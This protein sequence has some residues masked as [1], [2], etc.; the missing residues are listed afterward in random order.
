[1]SD[2][3][4]SVEAASDA[5][6][7]LL[8]IT[9]TPERGD[10]LERLVAAGL[11]T[12]G[13]DLPERHVPRD[14]RPVE[15]TDRVTAAFA[16]R[17][18]PRQS[19]AVLSGGR[20]LGM[21]VQDCLI[22]TEAQPAYH[23]LPSFSTHFPYHIV[24]LLGFPANEAHT[25]NVTLQVFSAGTVRITG[26]GSPAAVVVGQSSIRLTVPVEVRTT[27]GGFASVMVQRVGQT[28]FDWFG[29]DVF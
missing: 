17:V 10:V 9:T 6:T 12:A 16:G 25:V 23:R 29:A 26:T 28:G 5:R 13:R 14:V 3:R 18:D 24:Y 4:S 20:V 11:V 22:S 1:M 19:R 15:E 27:A 21:Y 7:T 2:T 8:E